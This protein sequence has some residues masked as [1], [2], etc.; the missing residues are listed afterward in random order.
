MRAVL[1]ISD[2]PAVA[3][4]TLLRWNELDHASAHV[5]AYSCIVV[6]P[7]P[8]SE[9]AQR[10]LLARLRS[11]SHLGQW[12]VL[13]ILNE[14]VVAEVAE[15]CGFGRLARRDLPAGIVTSA[16]RRLRTAPSHIQVVPEELSS[17]TITI[18]HL[19][20]APDAPRVPIATLSQDLR[21]A[22]APPATD[23]TD[24]IGLN[25]KAYRNA[26]VGLVALLM[27]VIGLLGVYARSKTHTA[28]VD[29]HS[30]IADFDVRAEMGN[31]ATP[32]A[33]ALP[34][35]RLAERL[36]WSQRSMNLLRLTT[37]EANGSTLSPEELWNQS[38]L[39]PT[40]RSP[41][42]FRLALLSGDLV[43][44]FRILLQTDFKNQ[45]HHRWAVLL[46][47][48]LWQTAVESLQELDFRRAQTFTELY[49]AAMDRVSLMADELDVL[50]PERNRT[51]ARI[52]LREAK[53]GRIKSL[54]N[55]PAQAMNF[56]RLLGGDWGERIT[57]VGSREREARIRKN[58][59]EQCGKVPPRL[60][61][62][63]DPL[64]KADD[65]YLAEEGPPS[66]S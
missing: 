55:E 14:H 61:V 36:I 10:E 41:A 22:A 7:A 33:A 59:A 8:G 15:V 66:S 5:F 29:G 56:A 50:E 27:I 47:D 18:A 57:P 17:E 48:T 53:S 16:F 35:A 31:L 45:D 23:L 58:R 25:P 51:L 3:G 2:T 20:S 54:C 52:L 42:Y 37:K 40:V 21:W 43:S 32:N 4:A 6:V 63:Y 1:E 24:L 26:F 39:P 19:Q 38:Q 64:V 62:S 49:L 11:E 28:Y 65:F 44:A 60:R 34:A 30:A 9:K 13:W 46:T 12:R